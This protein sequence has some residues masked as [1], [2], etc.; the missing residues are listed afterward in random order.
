MASK[1]KIEQLETTVIQFNQE[2][3]ILNEQIKSTTKTLDKLQLK[4]SDFE[5]YRPIFEQFFL[6]FPG[7]DPVKIIQ[8]IKNKKDASI[9]IIE[10]SNQYQQKIINLEKEK[11]DLY[12]IGKRKNE[13]L[14]IKISRLEKDNQFRI[15][16][17]VNEIKVLKEDLS[18]M[19]TYKIENENLKFML[20]QLYNHL[21][22]RLRIDKNLKLDPSLEVKEKDF[23][24]NLFDNVDII[25][26]IRAML[27][28]SSEEKSSQILREVIAYSNMMLRNFMKDKLH[29]KWNP[30]QIFKDTKDLIEKLQ[31]ENH[32]FKQTNMRL[33]SKIES[34][35]IEKKKLEKEIKFKI[36]L[37]DNLE[38]KYGEQ[39]DEK[40]RRLRGNRLKRSQKIEHIE[41]DDNKVID[42][43]KTKNDVNTSE[44]QS[45]NSKLDINI[46]LKRPSTAVQFKDIKKEKNKD[47][48]VTNEKRPGTSVNKRPA[49]TYS[50]GIVSASTRPQTGKSSLLGKRLKAQSSFTI[51][52]IINKQKKINQKARSEINTLNKLPN[53]I[54]DDIIVPIKNLKMSKNNDKLTTTG[55]FNL[56]ENHKEG[57]INLVENTNKLFLCKEKT[58]PYSTIKDGDN[59]MFN[60]FKKHIESNINKLNKI[61]QKL[62][63]PYS[64]NDDIQLQIS[65]NINNLIKNLEEK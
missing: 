63:K 2:N 27:N 15:E 19:K 47:I 17:Y 5:K 34:L 53:D 26:Y 10:E 35:E 45:E 62:N 7:D 43:L 20:F 25:R 33:S 61:S 8:D 1:Q 55:K 58:R 48:F 14:S 37:Y 11:K 6:E 41:V 65:Q 39:F 56:L 12:D 57:L 60:K 51:T 16:E 64:K 36:I 13:D 30:V 42:P 23:K 46:N 24:P 44:N 18:A 50:R 52:Y 31:L 29:N 9:K 32:T 22:E 3:T 40:I 59:N 21:I 28:T 49:T 38:K 4:F 54:N